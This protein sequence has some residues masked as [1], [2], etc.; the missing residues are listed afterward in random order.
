MSSSRWLLLI[1]L[2]NVGALALLLTWQIVSRSSSDDP[3]STASALPEIA[4]AA[5]ELPIPSRSLDVRADGGSPAE[6]EQADVQLV[7]V[8]HIQS[9]A[10]DMAEAIVRTF[11]RSPHARCLLGKVHLRCGSPAGA[12]ILWEQAL[13]IDPQCVEALVDLGHYEAHLGH[14]EEASRYFRKALDIDAATVSAYLPLAEVLQRRGDH[15]DASAVLES[16]LRRS[17]DLVPA[18]TLLGQAESQQGKQL[19]AIHCYQQALQRDAHSR[20]ALVGLLAAQRANG[21]TVSAADTGQKLADLSAAQPRVASDRGLTNL[22]ELKLHDWMSFIC[23]SA[24]DILAAEQNNA[25]AVELLESSLDEL[26]T[27]FAVRRKAANLLAAQGQPAKAAHLL[28]Q[29]CEL[30]EKDASK[31]RELAVFC[32]KSRQMAIA[33]AALERLLSLQPDNAHALSL[34]AQVEMSADRDPRQAVVY[35]QRAVAIAPTAGHYY[36]LATALYHAGEM[37]EARKFLSKAVELEPDN[38]EFR[39]ALRRL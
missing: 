1:I 32:I 25:A 12:Q 8:R 38:L 37:S 20:E 16:L 24:A 21:D 17:P 33:A 7:E 23:Q 11:P 13:Q 18:W 26:P 15:A 34:F 36:I 5:R 10:F 19:E 6:V 2:V 9:Y 27:L 22:D 31:W 39:D 30:A 28:Q 29:G 4:Q 3:V 14:N 35:A